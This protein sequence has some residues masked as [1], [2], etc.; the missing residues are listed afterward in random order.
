M[1]IF[2]HELG[3]S[4]DPSRHLGDQSSVILES[5]ASRPRKIQWLI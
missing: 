5:I 1:Y 2:K 4:W 3:T